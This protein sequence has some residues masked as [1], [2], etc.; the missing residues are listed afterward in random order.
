[1]SDDSASGDAS[2]S[3]SW[4]DLYGV[5]VIGC[6]MIAEGTIGEDVGSFVYV[7]NVKGST[8]DVDEFVYSGVVGVTELSSMG[9]LIGE[10]LHGIGLF[11]FV[12]YVNMV[13]SL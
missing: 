7:G 13:I 11:C 5:L 9:A 1:M 12:A 2:A 3:V 4:L 8:G 6:G 10:I